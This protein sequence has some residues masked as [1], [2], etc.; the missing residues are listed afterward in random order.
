MKRERERERE[1]ERG[2]LLFC[3]K[4]VS[5]VLLLGLLCVCVCVCVCYPNRHDSL[6]ISRLGIRG[7]FVYTTVSL[8]VSPSLP[9]DCHF[10]PLV[11]PADSM[12]GPQ[13]CY[14]MN[15]ILHKLHHNQIGTFRID[16]DKDG[17]CI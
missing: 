10:L 8:C 11:S 14:N 12:V 4:V 17:V 7:I 3:A 13:F 5:R 15:P 16:P 9:T 2:I 1:R 6:R